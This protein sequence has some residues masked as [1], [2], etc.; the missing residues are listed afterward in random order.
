MPSVNDYHLDALGNWKRQ[1]DIDPND[2]SSQHKEQALMSHGA[3]PL[4]LHWAKDIGPESE[5]DEQDPSVWGCFLMCESIHLLSGEAGVGKTTL[6]YNLAISA[7]TGNAF[8][9]IQFSESLRVLYIDLE[10]PHP[11]W[12]KKI[13]LVSEGNP[14]NNLA[15]I[16]HI[17]LRDEIRQLIDEVNQHHF[18][19]IIIDT[20]NEAFQTLD[21]ND[22]AEANRQMA[23]IRELIQQTGAAVVLVHHVGKSAEGKKVYKGRGA[24]ARAASADVVLNLE[25]VSEEVIKLELVKNR[26][27]GGTSKLF[28]RKMGEDFFEPTEVSGEESVSHRIEAQNSILDLLAVACTDMSTADIKAQCQ[29]EGFVSA[30]IERALSGLVQVGKVHRVK[31]GFYSL[32]QSSIKTSITLTPS[33]DVI[34]GRGDSAYVTEKI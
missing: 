19:L 33:S 17:S 29:H 30:T 20:M 11:L 28:L 21:E 13:R 22:N 18:G 9:G 23:L 25:G 10:T 12:R 16:F 32:S 27:V 14:P 24:S 5:L 3:R 6:L 26:W 4:E 15:F 1:W 8:L 31:R 34:D 7:C 2:L